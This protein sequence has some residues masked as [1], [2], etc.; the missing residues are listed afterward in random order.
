[1]TGSRDDPSSRFR[2]RQFVAPL[3]RCGVEV[4]E[5]RPWISKFAGAP[6]QLTGLGLA[7]RAV[8]ACAS[9]GYDLTWLNRELVT[10]YQ[11]LESFMGR[12]RLLDVD[13]AIW[14]HGRPD[15]A[16]RIAAGCAGVIAGNERIAEYFRPA[17]E[18]VWT[19]PT[20]VD[21]DRWTPAAAPPAGFT[22]G[23][24]GTHWNLSYLRAI[25]A[26]LARFLREHAEAR[27]LV[28][29]DRRPRLRQ[30][31]AGQVLFLPWSPATEVAALRRMNVALVPLGDDDWTRAKCATKM[32]CAM[33]VGLPVIVSPVGASAEI[34]RRAS[35][36]LAAAGPDDWYE[37]LA[38]LHADPAQRV[39]M[40]TAGRQVVVEG[41]AVAV[42]V[43]QLASIFHEVVGQ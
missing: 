28:V 11:T 25:E 1:M 10:G 12:H 14:M 26:P 4:V 38:Q 43:R 21:T 22:I 2:V 5:H 17:V 37:A 34:L 13:D 42:A 31:P 27:L 24:S 33:A 23:W 8:H 19:V 32:L 3:G 36:G 7:S 20:A 40:G 35:L 30:L 9:R 29:C 6:L 39:A 41:Y 16:R 15:F 18:R